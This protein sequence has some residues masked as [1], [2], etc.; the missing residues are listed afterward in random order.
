[1]VWFLGRVPVAQQMMAYLPEDTNLASGVNVGH[2]Q[3]YPEFYKTISQASGEKTFWK[4]DEVLNKAT[5]AEIDYAVYGTGPSGFAWVIRTKKEFDPSKLEKLSGAKSYSADGVTYY[6]ATDTT[7]A[8]GGL[9]V[10]APTNRIAVFAQASIPDG[11]FREMLKGNTGNPDK[12]LLGRTKPLAKRISRGTWWILSDVR[13][14]APQRDPN[15][16]SME[17]DQ[18]ELRR[19]LA[20]ESSKGTAWGF[21]ASAGSKGV[22]FEVDL[23]CKDSTTASELA[24]KWKESELAKGDEGTPPKWWKSGVAQRVGD[25]KVQTELLASIGFANSGEIFVVRSEVE[26]KTMMNTVGSMIS[27]ISAVDVT[28]LASAPRP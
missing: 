16:G 7:G 21:K 28:G 24:K 2:L 18:A 14:A 13:V 3:K 26:T 23:L 9:K 20:E 17:Q 5:G 27:N 19:V 22:R 1:L 12:T 10:F 4:L 15:A 25:Q 6:T 8:F 11:K